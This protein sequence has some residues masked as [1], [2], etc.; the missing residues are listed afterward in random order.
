[1]H[2]TINVSPMLRIVISTMISVIVHG[3]LLGSV[4]ESPVPEQNGLVM[5]IN[6]FSKR[7]IFL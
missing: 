2:M 1:M 4:L 3:G 7:N 6:P 5:K